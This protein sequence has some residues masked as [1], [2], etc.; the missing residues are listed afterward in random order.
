M[1]QWSP[2]SPYNQSVPKGVGI[3]F[4]QQSEMLTVSLPIWNAINLGLT[5]DYLQFGLTQCCGVI[6]WPGTS[7]LADF[8]C[9]SVIHMSHKIQSGEIS[10]NRTQNIV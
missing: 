4:T 5:F 3:T 2:R 10:L 1:G 6:C 9:L 7:R 8:P